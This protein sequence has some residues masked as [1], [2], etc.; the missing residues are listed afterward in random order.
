MAERMIE[1][2]EW[3]LAFALKHLR[4]FEREWI[5]VSL[6]IRVAAEGFKEAGQARMG[7]DILLRGSA[8]APEP[9]RANW[10]IFY[11]RGLPSN[12]SSG[13]LTSK[14]ITLPPRRDCRCGS[15]VKANT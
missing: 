2:E 5:T 11:N 7:L 9:M 15:H 13:H 10:I 4:A 3:K 1:I 6:L 14:K 12:A 8:V